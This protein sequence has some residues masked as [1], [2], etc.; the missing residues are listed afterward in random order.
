VSVIVN[1]G[2]DLSFWNVLII[3]AIATTY[4]KTIIICPVSETIEVVR[5]FLLRSRR[6]SYHFSELKNLQIENYEYSARP[7]FPGK[8]SAKKMSL[9]MK[10]EDSIPVDSSSDLDYIDDL[11][12]K[13]SRVCHLTSG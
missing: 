6:K 13:I 11:S 7:P 8:I 1:H 5:S 2:K 12:T 9:Q 10:N 3:L 4:R